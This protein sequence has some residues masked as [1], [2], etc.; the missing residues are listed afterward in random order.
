MVS[1]FCEGSLDVFVLLSR[2]FVLIHTFPLLMIEMAEV[3]AWHRLFVEA[4]EW[5]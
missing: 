5:I 1:D 4:V 3:W 2:Q